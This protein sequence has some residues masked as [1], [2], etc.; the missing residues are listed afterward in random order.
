MLDN[1]DQGL[2]RYTSANQELARFNAHRILTDKPV[3]LAK[4]GSRDLRTDEA[5]EIITIGSGFDA[6]HHDRIL[7][8][9]TDAGELTRDGGGFAPGDAAILDWAT[10]MKARQTR[11]RK[12]NGG[13]S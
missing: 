2:G 8:H 12:A 4:I 1:Y 7:D 9:L 3:E 11:A 5:V 13:K 6:S 10:T